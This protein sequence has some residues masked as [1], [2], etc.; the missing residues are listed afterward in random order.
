MKKIISWLNTPY[1][2]NPFFKYKLKLS[3]SLG[4]FVFLFLYIFKPFY[5]SIFT[6]ITLLQYTSCI[7]F[8]TFLAVLIVVTIPPL[9]F[10]N[11]F[12]E[13][14][15]T[16]G[17]TILIVVV[18]TII[19]AVFLKYFGDYYKKQYG[20]KII[21]LARYIVYSL[22]VSALPLI[23]F[24][25]NNEKSIRLKRN[26]KAKKIVKAKNVIENIASEKVKIFAQNN[27]E[28]IKIE[29]KNLLYVTSQGNYASFF[30]KDNKEIKE[31]ILRTTLTK[32]DNAFKDNP[33]IIRCHKSYII[34]TNYVED[35][36]GNAR[37]YLLS[38]KYI[39][40]TIPV[41]RNF[42]KQSLESFLY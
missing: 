10:K 32:I 29:T 15:W 24:I 39:E 4:L 12:D 42:S 33:K 11:F 20:Y 35:I 40:T 16:I 26:I 9:F 28:S 23:L 41:S 25:F 8:F 5:L 22:L 14:K 7:G 38:V 17:K 1:Y 30:V 18:G 21:S 2:F 3:I 34:N 6:Q 37:G 27:K 31:K 13:D 36:T 19:T